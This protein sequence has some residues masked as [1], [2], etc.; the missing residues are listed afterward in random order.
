MALPRPDFAAVQTAQPPNTI[1]SHVT[2]DEFRRHLVVLEER[3]NAVPMDALDTPICTNGDMDTDAPCLPLK[4]EKQMA[5]DLAFVAAVTEGAQS[6]AAV[7]LEQHSNEHGLT[8]LVSVAGMDLVDEGVRDML[9][10]ITNILK[11]A[12]QDRDCIIEVGISHATDEIFQL[13]VSQHKQKLV[14]RLR[15]SKWT[16][17][18][19]LS[20]SHKKPLW[21][22][23]EN[24]VHR[25]QHVYP[26][27]SE[28]KL[29]EMVT[30]RVASLASVYEAFETVLDDDDG[31]ELHLRTLVKSTFAFCKD[32]EIQ[33]FATHL[34][35]VRATPQIAAV[36]K[37]LHQLEKIAAY[38]RIAWSLVA[39]A[40]RY[41]R[42]FEN[43]AWEYL[44]P[45]AS[46]PT[47]IAYESWAKTCHVHAEIQLVAHYALKRARMGV[48]AGS[49][50]WPRTI[51]TSKYLCYLCYLFLK[52]YRGFE[53]LNT[54][55]RLYDQ[56][57][58]PDLEGYDKHTRGRIAQTLK[59]IDD[60][61]CQ[62][63]EVITE[64]VWRV[65]PMTS[66]QNLLCVD[67]TLVTA[68]N[69]SSFVDEK[70]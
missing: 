32:P 36:L 55:G 24:V 68:Y 5:D 67:E 23:F 63:I 18:R 61:V 65:E 25:V 57:T 49:W 2:E 16:K 51:G 22:D 70:K 60:H 58:A 3:T 44:M 64:P 14:G 34:E 59:Q 20:L 48:K 52:Y 29:R 19:H 12:I 31:D 6:V 62:Q 38:W 11:R 8:L 17:P 66:R 39:T 54:H 41:P 43:V 53:L 40:M 10:R 13:I 15:S 69:S 46:V 4:F 26:K 21:R 27:R 45:Y 33:R 28:R 9:G 35:S 50:T 37:T 30:A 42:V 47:S 1:W 7:C 56:W